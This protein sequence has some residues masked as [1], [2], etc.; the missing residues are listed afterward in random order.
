MTVHNWLEVV[1]H[2]II[3]IL[4]Y[5]TNP[6][7]FLNGNGIDYDPHGSWFLNK[8]KEFL[9]KGF[10]VQKYCKANQEFDSDNK[11]LKNKINNLRIILASIASKQAAFVVSEKSL[12]DHIH[13]LEQVSKYRVKNMK[14]QKVLKSSNP[15]IL[16]LKSIRM[17]NYHSSYSWYW[18]TEDFQN[19]YGPFEEIS[20]IDTSNVQEDETVHDEMNNI[21]N[22]YAT[23]VYDHI[24]NVVDVDK[25]KDGV[26]NIS[27]A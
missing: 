17:R 19:K 7:H 5:Q 10:N 6:S 27:I 22:K 16:K 20:E 21:D 8:G 9:S 24:D 2:E 1:L 23:Q 25:V 13:I 11:I 14:L 3:H 15:N 26:Y 12:E 4:D 18:F